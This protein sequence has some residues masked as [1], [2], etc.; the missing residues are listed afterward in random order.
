MSAKENSWQMTL[1]LDENFCLPNTML[2]FKK[3]TA[4]K[5]R[6]KLLDISLELFLFLGQIMTTWNKGHTSFKKLNILWNNN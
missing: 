1:Q 3:Y 6:T 4:N 5:P 2:P